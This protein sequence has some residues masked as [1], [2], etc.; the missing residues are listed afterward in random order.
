MRTWLKN[1]IKILLGFVLLVV[2]TLSGIFIYNWV[3]EFQPESSTLLTTAGSTAIKE[4]DRKSFTFISWNIGYAGLGEDVDF[5]YDGGEGVKPDLQEFKKY[6]KGIYSTIASF[7]STDFLLFQEVDISSN[8]SYKSN[9]AEDICELLNGYDNYFAVNYDVAYVPIPFTRPLGKVKSGIQLHS[10]ISPAIV[11]KHDY[12]SGYSWPYR[13]FMPKR[14]YLKAVYKLKSGNN[15]VIYNTHHSAFDKGELRKAEFQFI[16]D[17]MLNEYLR[18]NYVVAGGDWNQNPP[19]FDPSYDPE[20]YQLSSVHPPLSKTVLPKGW[21]WA[22]SK[23]IPTNRSIDRPFKKGQTRTT[24]IDYFIVSPNLV[25]DTVITDD[26]AFR[27]SDHQPVFL[28]VSLAQAA[29]SSLMLINE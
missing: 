24:I 8:R 4:H 29:E 12:P 17:D 21:Q 27:H 19:D 10:N 26:L 28:R 1:T 6:S 22:W 16:R 14:A 20:G 9:Q 7:H 23:G 5:F 13:L 3:M 11:E 25:V 2:L 18:G 15:L